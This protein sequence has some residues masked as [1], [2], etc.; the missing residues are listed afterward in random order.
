MTIRIDKSA[1]RRVIVSALEIVESGFLVVDVPTVAQGVDVCQGARS[2]NDFSVG[3]VLI[4]CDN[5]LAGIHNPRRHFPC[6]FQQNLLCLH[7]R[8]YCKRAQNVNDSNDLR[9]QNECK[10][11]EKD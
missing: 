7:R 1:D 3:V 2:G 8:V 4:A 6:R 9:H 11:N 5:V 10:I